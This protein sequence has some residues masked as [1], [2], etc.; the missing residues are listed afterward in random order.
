Y[1]RPLRPSATGLTLAASKTTSVRPLPQ[2]KRVPSGEYVR[3]IPTPWICCTHSGSARSATSWRVWTSQTVR[4]QKLGRASR[5]P[6]G[7]KRKIHPPDGDRSGHS[8]T[9]APASNEYLCRSFDRYST[10][11]YTAR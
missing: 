2:T 4:L 1:G 7:E 11:E 6:S 10:F 3:S 9:Q 8:S 5:V